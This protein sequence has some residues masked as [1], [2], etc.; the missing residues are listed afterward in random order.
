[1][2]STGRAAII[3]GLAA[4]GVA[5][6]TLFGV[7]PRVFFSA[8]V[9]PSAAMEDTIAIGDRVLV[10]TYPRID[11]KFGDLIVVISP[12]NRSEVFLKRVVGLPGDRIRIADRVLY[13][14]GQP[15][16]EPYA[17]FIRPAPDPQLDNYPTP[18]SRM[19]SASGIYALE[20]Y[21]VNGELV[22]PP[23]H[24]FVLGDN[25][26]NSLDDRFT[27]VTPAADIVGKAL[28]VYAHAWGNHAGK[29]FKPL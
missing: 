23:K 22:V 17:K 28:F 14:N 9:I 25:R 8:Y 20:H 2:N 3:I 27:G 24:V 18:P 5:V 7:A 16:S 15:Q 10:R 13:R 21:V 12:V 4:A 19:T 6:V 1:M 29:L 11:P 26:E